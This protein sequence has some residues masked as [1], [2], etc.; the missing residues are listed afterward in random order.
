[1]VKAAPSAPFVMAEA[2][3]LLELLIVTLDAPAQLGEIDQRPEGDVLGKGRE[4]V[5][6]R[7]FL[8][9][10]PLDQQPF[11][12]P[13]VGELIVMMRGTYAHARKTRGQPF[14]R[15]LPPPDRAPGAL[16]QAE[17][18]L[19]DRDRLMLVVAANELRSPPATRPL[20][21]RQRALAGHPN[22]GLRQ[23]AG[24]I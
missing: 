21:R 9:L 19:L 18:K 7:L 6:G 3:L 1:M 15:T 4:P 23:D 8:V 11:F 10:G 13:A 12:R 22:G 14:S 17:R 2:D 24:H 5:F 20:L 16:G